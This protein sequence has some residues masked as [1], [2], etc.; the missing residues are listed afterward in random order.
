MSQR[1]H[2]ALMIAA[3]FGAFII[4]AGIG[5][6]LFVSQ[7]VSPS[8]FVNGAILGALLVGA[9]AIPR[10]AF[11]HLIGCCCTNPAC[12]GTAYP[13]GSSPIVYRC[14]TCGIEFETSV[15]EGEDESSTRR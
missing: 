8:L 14:R 13:Q 11:R 3:E 10:L 4:A 6:A 5:I 9:V 1:F 15:S 12:T 7:A 2:L